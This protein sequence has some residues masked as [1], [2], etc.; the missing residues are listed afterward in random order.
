MVEC[1]HCG[2]QLELEQVWTRG[3]LMECAVCAEM[4]ERI[5]WRLSVKSMMEW[6]LERVMNMEIERMEN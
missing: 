3:I 5:W 2:E 1:D 6:W 4:Q